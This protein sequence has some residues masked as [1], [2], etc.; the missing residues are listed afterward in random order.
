MKAEAMIMGP[1]DA[2]RVVW[3]IREFF[4]YLFHVL[5]LLTSVFRYYL[6]T[7]RLRDTETTKTGPND[8]SRVV[9]AIRRFFLSF[10][11]VLLMYTFV[12]FCS[13]LCS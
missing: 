11:R 10:F 8:A 4:L 5:L 3:A 2:K 1:N 12:H 7:G 9:W 13:L 6:S